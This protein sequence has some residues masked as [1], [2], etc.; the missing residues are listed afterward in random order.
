MSRS[1]KGPILIHEKKLANLAGM[2]LSA[3]IG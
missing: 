2:R 1:V 3:R